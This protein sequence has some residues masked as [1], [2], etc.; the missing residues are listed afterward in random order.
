[1][2]IARPTPGQRD[3]LQ[4]LR[5][6]GWRSFIQLNLIVSDHLLKRMIANGW[7]ERRSMGGTE[8]LKLT[9]DGLGALRAK[10]PLRR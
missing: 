5:S 2:T 6:D 7:I 8:E 4:R 9:A 1:M 10:I 3:V